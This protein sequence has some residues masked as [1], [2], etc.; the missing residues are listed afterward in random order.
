MCLLSYKLI[1]VMYSAPC[2]APA[3]ETKPARRRI[4]LRSSPKDC[5]M[6]LILGYSAR[7]C[8]I[9]LAS[10]TTIK[11]SAPGHEAAENTFLPSQE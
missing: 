3:E 2:P 11:V 6:C 9:K 5:V 7:S 1:Q 10:G 8:L 4:H